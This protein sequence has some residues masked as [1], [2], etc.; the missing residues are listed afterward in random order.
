MLA[1]FLLWPSSET[2]ARRC[3]APLAVA[4]N[5]PL[6]ETPSQ[7]P[8]GFSV[9]A[10]E[11]HELVRVAALQLEIFAPAEE[12]PPMIPMLQ[13]LFLANQRANRKGMLRRLT[14]EIALRVEKGSEILIAIG[15]DEEEEE[16]AAAAAAGAELDASGLYTEPGPPVLGTV[17]ISCQEMQLPTHAIAEGL[18][19][20][21]MAVSE[22]SRR[23]GIA[24][25]LLRE[26]SASALRRGEGCLWLHVEPDNTPAVALY[27]GDGYVRMPDEVAPYAGFTTALSLRERAVLYRKA[28]EAEA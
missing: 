22:R 28:L 14:D 18:Y 17:D 4:T 8:L 11:T 7:L 20:S 25:E 15:S 21:H 6:V 3:P 2:A 12:P 5:P 19:L 16:D 24:R 26:A 1:S 27:E 13:S 23:R 9:R 10:A